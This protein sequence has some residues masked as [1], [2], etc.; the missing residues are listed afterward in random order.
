MPTS[1]DEVP[2][3]SERVCSGDEVTNNEV[4]LLITNIVDDFMD[5]ISDT[6]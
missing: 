5:G 6:V 3:L 2:T 4:E 1:A